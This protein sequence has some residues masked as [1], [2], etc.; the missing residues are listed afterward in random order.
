MSLVLTASC[1]VGVFLGPVAWIMGN[2]AIREIDAAPDVYSNRGQ[3]QAGRICG[4]VATALLVLGVIALLVVLALF[5][6]EAETN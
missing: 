4:M 3:V 2:N 1:L 6:A 5:V